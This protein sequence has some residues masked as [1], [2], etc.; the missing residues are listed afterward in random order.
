MKY[1]F[2]VYQ[3]GA[4]PGDVPGNPQA[5]KPDEP[6]PGNLLY[7][8]REVEGIIPTVDLIAQV[9][10]AHGVTSEVET[11]IIR[12]S[13]AGKLSKGSSY[14]SALPT[15][16]RWLLAEPVTDQPHPLDERTQA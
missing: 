1:R 4:A 15:P 5:P 3:D 13:A 14:R 10:Q 16:G 11:V 6:I 8:G 12:G 7:P 2:W 9:F